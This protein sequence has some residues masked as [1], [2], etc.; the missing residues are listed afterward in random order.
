MLV[1]LT[2]KRVPS[3]NQ[4]FILGSSEVSKLDDIKA[5]CD[6]LLF[7]KNSGKVRPNF[8]KLKA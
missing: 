5:A 7:N 4:K 2:R 1:Q 8:V 3:D 6:Y